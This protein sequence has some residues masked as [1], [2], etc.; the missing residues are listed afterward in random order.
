MYKQVEDLPAHL[1]I[2]TFGIGGSFDEQLVTRVAKKGRGSVSRIYDLDQGSLSSAAVLALNRA[3]YPS[4]P[5]CNITWSGQKT[6]NLNEVFYNQLISSYRIFNASDF[7]NNKIDFTFA[8][9]ENIQQTFSKND[10]M[11]VPTKSGFFKMAARN[12]VT[13]TKD[14][15]KR[16][17]I[18]LRYQVLAPETAFV[19]VVR[20]EGKL[21][22]ETIKVVID[23]EEVV[24]EMGE[25][26]DMMSSM[27]P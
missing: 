6:E 21:T 4:L 17:K 27:R 22:N 12:L 25:E 7:D 10:F 19:G 8:C 9:K 15:A 23:R 24:E 20:E 14:S 5:G 26:M 3:M 2:S 1:R 11:Q 13:R 18:S 16:E